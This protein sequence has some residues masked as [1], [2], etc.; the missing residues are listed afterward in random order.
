MAS[1]LTSGHKVT[2]PQATIS[3][4]ARQIPDAVSLPHLKL[5]VTP[6]VTIPDDLAPRNAKGKAVEDLFKIV[7]PIGGKVVVNWHV[8]TTALFGVGRHTDAE[9]IQRMLEDKV[10]EWLQSV[11]VA[12]TPVIGP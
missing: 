9:E 3:I 8:D 4:P 11:R 2:L 7:V 10:R 1:R 5:T 6:Q 12:H